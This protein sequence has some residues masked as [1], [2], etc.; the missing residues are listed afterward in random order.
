MLSSLA[1][2][3]RRCPTCDRPFIPR[4][5]ATTRY[6]ELLCFAKADEFKTF[7]KEKNQ[8]I[9]DCQVIYLMFELPAYN[10]HFSTS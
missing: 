3:H 2:L 6:C 8:N 4:E 5:G 10:T 7:K 9:T 1:V